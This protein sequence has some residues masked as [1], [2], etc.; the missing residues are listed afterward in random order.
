MINKL[1]NGTENG[2]LHIKLG[3]PKKIGRSRKTKY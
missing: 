2:T 1:G 3:Y